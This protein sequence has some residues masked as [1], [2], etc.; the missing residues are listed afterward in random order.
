MLINISCYISKYALHAGDNK[1][2]HLKEHYNLCSVSLAGE[3]EHT[4]SEAMTLCC[5]NKH[6]CETSY[7]EAVTCSRHYRVW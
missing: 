7:C 2:G 3:S 5:N 6:A 1:G 4:S